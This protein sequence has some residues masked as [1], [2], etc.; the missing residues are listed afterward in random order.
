MCLLQLAQNISCISMLQSFSSS[1]L[2]PSFYGRCCFVFVIFW[3]LLFIDLAI[4]DDWGTLCMGKKWCALCELP[5]DYFDEFLKIFF[6]VIHFNWQ[7]YEPTKI[8]NSINRAKIVNSSTPRPFPSL[9]RSSTCISHFSPFFFASL[10]HIS[11][12]QP[13]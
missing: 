5:C 2:F 6:L 8:Y 12:F 13:R 4:K 11:H 7:I 10:F 9:N 3:R 1:S